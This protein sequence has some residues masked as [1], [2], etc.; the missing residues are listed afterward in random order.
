MEN[1]TI[2][3]GIALP[4]TPTDLPA[5]SA[6]APQPWEMIENGRYQPRRIKGSCLGRE[7]G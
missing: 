4:E 1:V 7:L 2:V 3:R 6:E 5:Q